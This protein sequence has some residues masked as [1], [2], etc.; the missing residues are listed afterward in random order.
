[1]DQEDYSIEEFKKSLLH[2]RFLYLWKLNLLGYQVPEHEFQDLDNTYYP[3]PP[4][5]NNNG[6]REIYQRDIDELQLIL[7][8]SD[9]DS[10]DSKESHD[11]IKVTL[12]KLNYTLL[13]ML[14]DK[15]HYRPHFH[16]QYKEEYSA[17]YA[18]DNFEKLAGS[19]PLKYE[20]PILMW[21]K[22]HSESLLLTWEK[23]RAGENI[24]AL[25]IKASE[26]PL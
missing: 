26:A 3:N 25:I 10:K 1:M 21:A 24:Q 5:I 13:K 17:S 6:I 7:A 4:E 16:I 15:N 9:Q 11:P 18:I 22:N 20:T 12:I 19:V 14:P 23:M 8:I 2:Q